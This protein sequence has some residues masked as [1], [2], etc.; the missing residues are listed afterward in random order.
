MEMS[1]N[2]EEGKRVM[3]KWMKSDSPRFVTTKKMH[4]IFRHEDI[5]Y[6]AECFIMDTNDGRNKQYPLDIKR[7][8]DKH[9]M[10]FDLIPPSQPLDKG[11]EHI[12]ELE[13][14]AKPVIIAPYRPQ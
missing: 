6:A 2:T 13:E 5:V 1:F 9:K 4:A 12:I 7:I 11:F 8:L 3:L 10:V 14:G